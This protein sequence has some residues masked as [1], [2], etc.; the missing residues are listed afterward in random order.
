MRTDYNCFAGEWP[1]VKRRRIDFD[2][3]RRMHEKH[4]ITS[5]WVSNLN[6]VFYNDPFEGDEELSGIISGS[7]YKHAVSINPMLPNT[8]FDIKR[9]NESF[10]Y[11]AFRL[12]P[13]VHGYN[14]DSIEFI[15][16]MHMATPLGKPVFIHCAFGDARLDYLL[17]QKPLDKDSLFSFLRD[18]ADVPVI[19][20]NMRHREMIDNRDFLTGDNIFLDMSEMRHS[21]FS[22]EDMENA[23]LL[24]KT[25][26]G[27]FYPVFDFLASFK[28]FDG[29]LDNIVEDILERD[30]V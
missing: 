7:G 17:K 10:G 11:D 2:G 28:H 18:G 25:V 23:G 1:F 29:V 13:T 15:E 6:A 4:G 24:D 30:I 26:F 21:M 5:G 12:Y 22:L 27:S 16:F 19:L 20:C 9:L 14:F 8:M 3:L